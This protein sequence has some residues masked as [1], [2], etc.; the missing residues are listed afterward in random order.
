MGKAPGSRQGKR[1]AGRADPNRESC[2]AKSNRSTAI[3]RLLDR[4][5]LEG[6]VVT[7]NAAGCQRAIVQAQTPQGGEDGLQ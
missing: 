5:A 3:P 1:G 7:I 2:A 4:M 6:A